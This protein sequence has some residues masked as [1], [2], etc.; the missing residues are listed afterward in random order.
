MGI[1]LRGSRPS[2]LRWIPQNALLTETLCLFFFWGGG[3]GGGEV[4][5]VNLDNEKACNEE[6]H[7]VI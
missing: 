4:L 6:C 7:S 1:L 3:G 2:T 5:I